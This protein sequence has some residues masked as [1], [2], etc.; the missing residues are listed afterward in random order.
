[1]ADGTT[2]LKIKKGDLV[3][4]ITGKDRGKRG[5]VIE[6]RPSERRVL[7]EGLNQMKRHTRPRPVCD[8]ATRVAT[9]V[10]ERKGETSKIRVCRREGCGQEIDK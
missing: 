6:S 9:K 5:R 10:V 2:R 8:H 3:E 4:I 7:V 1:M